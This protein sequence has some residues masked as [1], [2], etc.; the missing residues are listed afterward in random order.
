MEHSIGSQLSRQASEEAGPDNVK[1][2]KLLIGPGIRGQNGVEGMRG[3]NKLESIRRMREKYMSGK[4][5][6][7]VLKRDKKLSHEG[8]KRRS[9]RRRKNKTRS[10]RRR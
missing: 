4:Y 7:H 6:E 1:Y 8:G 2:N 10:T 9:T 5:T 3:S